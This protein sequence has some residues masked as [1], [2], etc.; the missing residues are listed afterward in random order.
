MIKDNILLV[1][2]GKM[3]EALL[4]GIHPKLFSPEQIIV[5]E[6]D[7]ELGY[8]I[9]RRYGIKIVGGAENN[10]IPSNFKIDTVL[11]AIK[12]QDAESLIPNFAKITDTETLFLS[13]IAGK[14][15]SFYE[16]H[17]G[18][19]RYIV[20]T[21]PNLPALVG[22]GVTA[23]YANVN[24][25]SIHKKRAEDLFNAVG[26]TF[27]A[28]DEKTMDLVTAVSGSGPA[29]VFYFIE[30]L[31]EA[32][33]EL[34]LSEEIAMSLAKSTVVGSSDLAKNS[35]KSISQLREQVTSPN[36]TTD[37][38]LKILMDEHTGLK[39]LIQRTVKA[40]ER[41]AKELS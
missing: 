29:Y 37:A 33:R 34:G 9:N 10:K 31:Y 38:A 22:Q 11:F 24:C 41:R 26:E 40:A 7:P 13:I 12:P 4:K 19:E 18:K 27:W 35:D 2:C 8:D 23:L 39:P 28:K 36:G 17:L 30:S 5:L 6:K 1:G 32:G 3:G 14:T 15:T 25:T 21:M 20:R 16:K